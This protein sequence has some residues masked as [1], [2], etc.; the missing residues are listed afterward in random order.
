[1]WLSLDCFNKCMYV[2]NAIITKPCTKCERGCRG[3]SCGGRVRLLLYDLVIMRRAS[4]QWAWST[5][6]MGHLRRQEYCLYIYY[7]VIPPE[8]T[9]KYSS[10]S[11]SDQPE[12]KALGFCGRQRQLPQAIG[13][14]TKTPKLL[15]SKDVP[16]SGFLGFWGFGVCG[17]LGFVNW[18]K[19]GRVTSKVNFQRVPPLENIRFFYFF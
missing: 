7:N 15:R 6:F 10:S 16:A 19:I 1:M 18:K 13:C 4:C 2:V 11:R 3:G 12:A 8:A 5:V 9:H 17:F 14:R